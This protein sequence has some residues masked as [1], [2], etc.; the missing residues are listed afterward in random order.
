MKQESRLHQI[1]LIIVPRLV[2]W[3]MKLWFFTCRITEY[4]TENREQCREHENPVIATFWHHAI[5]YL[6]YHMRREL[7]AAVVSASKDGEYIARLGAM[8]GFRSVRGS[9]HRRGM[10]VLKESMK[11]LSEGWHMAIVADGSQG[12]ALIVQAGSIFLASKSGSPILPMTWSAS[13]YWT[14]SSWDRMIIPKPFSRINLFYGKPV[15]VPKD[16]KGEGIE[17][18][19][20][21][22]ENN[23]NEIYTQAWAVYGKQQH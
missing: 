4:N 9:R 19:R 15:H 11:F 18:Y 5:L 20:L 21:Q 7:V 22:V 1:G 3:L 8:F 13:R 2:A 12:P 10:Q 16:V 17:A 6:L 14:V 23:L